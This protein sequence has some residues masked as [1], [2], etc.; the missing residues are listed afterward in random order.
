MIDRLNPNARVPA[1]P[2]RRRP[3][4]FA[5]ASAAL[6][7][8]LFPIRPPDARAFCGFY[9][10]RADASLYN[11]ASQ[12]A[13][14]RHDD[15]T[16]ISMM[17]DFE[18]NL[19]E[20]AL[21]V[22]VPEILQKGQIH[23]GDKALFE[24]IDA[25]SAPRLVEY[26]DEDPCQRF[27]AKEQSFSHRGAQTL[28]MDAA[29]MAQRARTLGVTVEATYTIGEYDIV[30]LSAKESNGLET[31]LVE[32]GY[33]MPKGASRA[34]QPYIRQNMKFFVAKV[35]LKEQAKTG[36]TYLRPLQFAFR[37]DKFMLPIR[38]GM[39][40]AKGPQ[41]LLVYMLTREGRVETTNYRTVRLPSDVEIPVYVKD[42]FPDF[43]RAM[44][45]KAVEREG[46][47]AVFTEYVWN[48]GWC[49][50]CAADPMSRD[51]LRALGVFWL[52]GGN[53]KWGGPGGVGGGRIPAPQSGPEQ[54]M[55]TRLHVRYSRETFPEDLVFQETRDSG[56]FQGRYILR[57]AWKGSAGACPEADS[58][59]IEL[60]RRREQ[61]AQNLA[62]LT[63]WDI[64]MIRERMGSDVPPEREPW[65]WELWK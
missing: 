61:E 3:F 18:G 43:Y 11:K 62:R 60:R 34:L 52:D 55:I 46:M 17:N 44:F 36:V 16:V 32:N 22:P 2:R 38:L 45:D 8:A 40:N 7:A 27:A 24:H 14:V 28:A 57:H 39:I 29:G 51:E 59:F 63:G 26:F 41:D 31:W 13:V 37:S 47:R 5:L 15:K 10:S 56:N 58:Y 42:E 9:V 6:A 35:N 54:V 25:Y 12:V 49:D 50:P 21:V 1:R 19:S 30:I 4:R 64:A 65:W 53:E 48:M 33:R 20:F 23:V